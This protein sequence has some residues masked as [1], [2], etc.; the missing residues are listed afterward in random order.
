[1]SDF[2][3]SSVIVEAFDQDGLAHARCFALLNRPG[4][5]TASHCLAEV[6][7]AL[8]GKR[9][10]Q[11]SDAHLIISQVAEEAKLIDLRSREI[12]AVIKSAQARGIRGALLYD[13]LIARAAKLANASTTWTLNKGHFDIVSEG[14]AVKIP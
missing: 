2:V 12:L 5:A 9:H 14:A 8:T 3:D 10:F 4:R 7:S 11:P 1:M 13:S 6:F